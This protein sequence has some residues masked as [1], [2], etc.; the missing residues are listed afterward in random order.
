[1]CL[2]SVCIT[3]IVHDIKLSNF[4][5]AIS[6]STYVRSVRLAGIIIKENVLLSE[7][8]SATKI[9]WIAPLDDPTL[10]VVSE[11]HFISM[12]WIADLLIIDDC[13]LCAFQTSNEYQHAKAITDVTIAFI[14][15]EETERSSTLV[16]FH[17]TTLRQLRTISNLTCSSLILAM[18]QLSQDARECL[19][20][21]FQK[22]AICKIRLQLNVNQW[23][24]SAKSPFFP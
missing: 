22:S 1:M 20:K 9:H 13:R 12:I 8:R 6:A 19:V 2:L 10:H 7:G 24:T 14:E 18:C 16:L 11:K 23:S 5:K 17:A 4:C 21:W 3:D 15:W